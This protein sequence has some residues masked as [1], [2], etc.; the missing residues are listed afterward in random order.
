[1]LREKKL[2]NGVSRVIIGY[3]GGPDSTLM[4]EVLSNYKGINVIL[5]YLNHN[6]R[7]DSKDEENF[8]KRE[9]KRRGLKLYVDGANVRDYCNRFSFSIEEGAR[10]LRLA[11]LRKVKEEESANLIALGHNLDDKIENFFIRL[12]RGSGFGLSRMTYNDGDIL[13][14]L[15]DFR[16]NDI[17]DYLKENK[18]DFYIDPSNESEDYLR[19]RIRINLIPLLEEFQEGSIEN[20][21]RS[22]DNLRDIEKA[23]EKQIDGIKITQHLNYAEIDRDDF[24]S[25]PLS[26]KFLII[27]KMLSFF[28]SEL[29][30]KR[31][32]LERFP[33]R[34]VIELKSSKI[35][36]LPSRVIVAK[37]ID[38]KRKEVP[39]P[40]KISYGCYDIEAMIVYP[41]VEL[42]KNGCEFFDLDSLDLPV[43]IRK[44]RVGDRIV[45]FGAQNSRKLKDLFIDSK[46]PRVLRDSYP[47]IFD[48][49]GIILIPG[50]RRSNR[51]PVSEKTERIL[52]IGYKEVTNA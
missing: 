14:P 43:K 31:V 10:N 33:T 16:K 35:E 37:N 25:L 50:I 32:H 15:L 36:I 9:A 44:K 1:V 39:L 19:N 38:E 34:G 3:S 27:S 41:P 28:G 46:I 12:L 23:L 48:K 42:E 2:L 26:C 21:G 49:K 29:E 4:T 6:L 11:Y 5:A 51:A 20:I 47:I 7:K 8:V 22:I 24:A 30:L 45:A 17:I 18:I 52:K 13:R 40:G